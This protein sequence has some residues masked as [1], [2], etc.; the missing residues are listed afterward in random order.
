MVNRPWATREGKALPQETKQ[1]SS[2]ELKEFEEGHAKH[3]SCGDSFRNVE[4]LEEGPG[5]KQTCRGRGGGEEG[6]KLMTILACIGAGNGRKGPKES[7]EQM[8]MVSECGCREKKKGPRMESLSTLWCAAARHCRR[9]C[10]RRHSSTSD[11]SAR[12][13]QHPM[14]LS[15]LFLDRIEVATTDLATMGSWLDLSGARS[16]PSMLVSFEQGKPNLTT[17]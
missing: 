11:D 10:R 5:S 15:C 14:A 12:T 13:A 17:D 9:S 16:E 7:E 1:P 6:R 4:E 8:L 2:S 3:H